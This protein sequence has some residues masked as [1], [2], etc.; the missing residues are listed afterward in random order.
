MNVKCITVVAFLVSSLLSASAHAADTNAATNV[1]EEYYPIFSEPKSEA[2]I[3]DSSLKDKY[4]LVSV[5]HSYWPI[6]R[7]LIIELDSFGVFFRQP[8]PGTDG[9]GYG[10]SFQVTPPSPD[11]TLGPNETKY[12]KKNA[13]R[14][15]WKEFKKFTANGL[16][17]DLYQ[18][19]YPSTRFISCM[20]LINDKQNGLTLLNYSSEQIGNMYQVFLHFLK[21]RSQ[22]WHGTK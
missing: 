18:V 10:A 14:F 3:D 6:P 22:A 19:K 4:Y 12:T 21:E 2:P 15:G 7:K 1:C 5:F 20:V 13:I 16:T 9:E 11:I 8:Y 17:V